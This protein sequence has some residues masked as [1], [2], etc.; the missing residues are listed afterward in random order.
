MRNY[1]FLG[2]ALALLL[3][4][5]TIVAGELFAD[6]EALLAAMKS[7]PPITQED[8]DIIIKIY[9]AFVETQGNLEKLEKLCADKNITPQRL[10]VVAMKMGAG[11]MMVMM[12]EQVTRESIIESGQDPA[13]LPNDDELLLIEENID[14]IKSMMNG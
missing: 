9:P 11:A 13:M 3:S 12:K 14:A 2:M 6:E 7:E 5:C 10:H 1:R 8:I 4:C